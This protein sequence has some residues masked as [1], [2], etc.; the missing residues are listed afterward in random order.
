[1]GHGVWILVG[2]RM[3]LSACGGLVDIGNLQ[4]SLFMDKFYELI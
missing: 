1:V 2:S 4:S 3:A